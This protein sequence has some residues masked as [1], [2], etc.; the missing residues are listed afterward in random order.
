MKVAIPMIVLAITLALIAV[1]PLWPGRFAG[2]VGIAQGNA[3]PGLASAAN[4]PEQAITAFLSDV[5]KRNWEGAQKRLVTSDNGA[6]A[7][8]PLIKELAGSDGSLR[9][10]SNL[11]DWDVQPLHATD[12][13]AQV[14]T[15]LRWSTPV[16]PINDVR[17]LK[18]VRGQGGWKIVWP[19]PTF[20]EVPAQVIP[21]NYLRWDLVTS[22]AEGN[23]GQR[24]VDAPRVR[25]LSMN[26]V[27]Y[28]G[29]TIVLGEVVNEDTIPSFVNVNATLVDSGGS[30]IDEESS[31]DKISH[32]L[33][34]KQVSPYR[35]DFPGVDLQRIKNVHMDIKAALVPAS[36]DPVIGVMDQKLE[37]T[38]DG[39]AELSGQ[40]LDQSGQVVNIPHVLATFYDNSGRVI[41]VSDGYI[42]RALLPETPESFAV[43]V[44]QK[45]ADKVHSYHVVVNH[46]D[47]GNS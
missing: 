35:I 32:I 9:S 16:G 40:L 45:F 1:G 36:A 15:T 18:L 33:L 7:D 44:P 3:L 37:K 38:A 34:P 41:W 47:L 29:G 6:V 10:F 26:P 46:Y 2:T 24:S 17:D 21:V 42:E 43:E 5:Q 13:E 11:A 39:R 19:V 23:W 20:P 31:F 12:Q 28:Q 30:V 14:R 25:I 22:S 8:A 4:T 27:E